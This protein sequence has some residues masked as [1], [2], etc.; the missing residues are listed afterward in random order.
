VGLGR[1]REQDMVL[2]VNEAATN[3]IR[4]GGGIGELE[5]I[6]DDSRALIVQISDDGPGMPADAPVRD[7]S[8]EQAGGRGRY[9]IQKTCD[10]VEYRTGPTGTTVRLEMDVDSP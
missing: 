4:H 1:E 10:H 7:P 9:L 6:Q 8:S 3:A 5:L 2:A